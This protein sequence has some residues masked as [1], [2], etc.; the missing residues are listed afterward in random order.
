[1][2]EKDPQAAADTTK[3]LPLSRKSRNLDSILS[4]VVVFPQPARNVLHYQRATAIGGGSEEEIQFSPSQ[5][6]RE[7]LIPDQS[8]MYQLEVPRGTFIT[9][10]PN[11]S[12]SIRIQLLITFTGQPSDRNTYF[13]K[14]VLV[15][16]R[17]SDVE[18]M[19]RYFGNIR[20]ESTDEGVVNNLGDLLR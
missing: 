3:T 14:V 11:E 2:L 1:V 6:Q 12:R 9:N 13:Y 19:N 10:I 20:T 16:R 7:V 4:R 17:Y 8:S 18:E 15:A 5:T